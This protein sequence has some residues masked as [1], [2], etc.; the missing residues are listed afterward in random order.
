MGDDGKCQMNGIG[1]VHVKMFD[2]VVRDLIEVRYVLQM[3]KNIISIEA[4]ESKGLKITL[5]NVVLKI[6]KG[7][8]VVMKGLRSRNLYCL[9]GSYSYRC[10]VKSPRGG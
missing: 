9:K 8:I 4:M 10:L 3:K 1:T 6:T 2:S 7:S 5:E